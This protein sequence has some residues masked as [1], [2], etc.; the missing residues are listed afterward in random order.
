MGLSYPSK[1]AVAPCAAAVI[2]GDLYSALQPSD[3]SPCHK[4]VHIRIMPAEMMQG[5]RLV[6]SSAAVVLAHDA[7]LAT[8]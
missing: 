4:P 2:L 5:T 8:T 1:V 7:G 6:G 3:L